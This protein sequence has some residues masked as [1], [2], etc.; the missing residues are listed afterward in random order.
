[1]I[2]MMKMMRVHT[3]NTQGPQETLGYCGLVCDR[4]KQGL[5]RFLRLQTLLRVLDRV[6]LWNHKMRE[7]GG[8]N[9]EIYTKDTLKTHKYLKKRWATVG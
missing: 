5:Y 3:Q 1:M 2:K 7:N 8:E 9:D 4:S 6:Q